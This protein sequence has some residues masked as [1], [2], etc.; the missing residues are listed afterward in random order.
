MIKKA[1]QDSV[2]IPS[3]DVVAREIEGVVII[4]PIVSGIADI[5]DELFSLNETGKA[6]WNKLDGRATLGEI[7][8]SLAL[9]FNAPSAEIREDVMGLMSELLKRRIVI[10]VK[11]DPS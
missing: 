7:I 8:A 1:H 6:I 9:E 4:V 11:N 3:Q 10:E 2:Y 5:E